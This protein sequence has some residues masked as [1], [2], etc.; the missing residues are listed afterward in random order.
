MKHWLTKT[1]EVA[2]RGHAV[3]RA[4]FIASFWVG[5]ISVL[6]TLYPPPT[7]WVEHF[8]S[9]GLYKWIAS[10]L[11]AIHELVPFSLTGTV[12]VALALLLPAC[13][14]WRW[15]CSRGRGDR[16]T[17]IALELTKWTVAACAFLY[18]GFLLAWGANYHREPIEARLGLSEWKGNESDVARIRA[19][20]LTFIAEVRPADSERDTGRAV[21]SAA[22]SMRELTRKWDGSPAALPD[23]VKVVPGALL[24]RMMVLGVCSPFLVEPHVDG[25]LPPMPFIRV[26]SHE[27]AHVAGINGEAEADFA[28]WMAGL[29]SDDAYMRYAT[30]I[31]V[32]LSLIQDLPDE[33]REAAY[34]SLPGDAIAEWDLYRERLL[35]YRVAPLA[36]VGAP[37]YN[38]YLKA[39]GVRAGIQDYNRGASLFLAAWDKGIIDLT[40]AS[41]AQQ[42]EIDMRATHEY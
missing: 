6:L 40:I 5:V 30:A 37:A 3:R 10:V 1:E 15:K 33:E 23:H 32:Y 25:M 11:V 39:Q 16:R 13:A 31:H 24:M 28:G 27:L 17:A 8:Y 38:A 18:G 22:R 42:P 14:A 12:I 20:L 41:T 36:R 21:E 9:R 19:T 34:A 26:A 29:N 4:M 35:R 2:R 7:P